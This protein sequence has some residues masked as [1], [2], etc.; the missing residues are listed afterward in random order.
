MESLSSLARLPGDVVLMRDPRGRASEVRS[1]VRWFS[2]LDCLSRPEQLVH[3]TVRGRDAGRDADPLVRRPAD[4]EAGH[5]LAGASYR[6]DA[7]DVADGVLRETAAPALHVPVDGTH[8][9]PDRVRE[10]AQGEVDQLIVG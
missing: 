3:G 2:C 6:R 4:G 5:V 8:A 9:E 10:I 1:F 7:G